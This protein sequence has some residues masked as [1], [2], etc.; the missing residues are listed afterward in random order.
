MKNL[1]RTQKLI[2]YKRK[3]YQ[4]KKKPKK[5]QIQEINS[6]TYP[7]ILNDINENI[8]KK[9]SIKGL[10]QKNRTKQMFGPIERG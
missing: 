2:L 8:T 1:Q 6:K 10:I 9:N 7:Y 3:V 5:Q 4:T